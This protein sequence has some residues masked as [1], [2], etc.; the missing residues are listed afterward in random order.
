[1]PRYRLRPRMLRDVSRADMRVRL[2]GEEVEFPI[3]AAATGI[4]CMSHPDG[5]AAMAKGGEMY[6]A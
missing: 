2:F 1:M 3:C 6:I 5:E 4:Q